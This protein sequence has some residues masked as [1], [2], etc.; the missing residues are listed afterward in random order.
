MYLS[1]RKFS[2][3]KSPDAVIKT[4][5]TQ[6]LPLL[7]EMEG[8]RAYYALKF[9]DGDLGAVSIFDRKESADSANER[10]LNWIKQN[11][12]EQLP[13]P[14]RVLRGDV[15]FTHAAGQQVMTKTA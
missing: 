4:V 7:K 9:E 13:E 14:P 5:E 10:S 8:F 2:N 3:V 1:I 15:L 11:L 12:S 6:L